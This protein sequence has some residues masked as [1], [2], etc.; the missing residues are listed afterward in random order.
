[1]KNPPGGRIA[2]MGACYAL[3]TFA[4]NFYKQAAVLLAAAAALTDMESLATVLFSLP[5]VL[6]S[7]WAG[8]LADRVPK[9]RLIIAAKTLELAAMLA[10][11]CFLATV[12]WTG[13][14]AVMFLMAA[15]STLFSPAINGA[16]PEYFPPDKV[17]GVN[18]AIKAAS[19]LAI[20]AGM[21]L[22]GFF[23][24]LR[25]QFLEGAL[26]PPIS[27]EDPGAP[28]RAAAGLFLL[29]ISTA[30]I[31]TA[32]FLGRSPAP[33]REDRAPFPLAGPL[34]SLRHALACRKDAALFLAL[35]AD[36]WFYGV[37]VI[38]VISVANLALALGH[39]NT[40]AGLLSAV[41]MIGV[42]AGA[43]CAGRGKPESWRSSLVP[44]ASGMGAG[45]L[46]V[47]A[48]PLL[49]E[50]ARLAWL[51]LSLFGCGFC[52]GLYIIPLE[53]FIQIRP[54]AGE[55]GKIIAA[56]NFMAFAAMAVFG[57]AFHLIALLPPAANF[58]VY[59]L[60]TLVFAAAGV[61]PRLDRLPDNSLKDA[62]ACLPGLAARAL[63]SLRYKVTEKGLE[64]LPAPGAARDEKGP[65]ILFLPNHPALV[66]PIIVYSRL[67]GLWP[68]PLADEAR[69]RGCLPALAGRM[70]RAVLIPDMAAQG[71]GA[72]ARVREAVERISLALRE[73]DHVLLYPS[74]RASRDGAD[75]LGGNSAA[76]RL[77]AAAPG[78]RVVL[79]RTRGLWGSDFSYAGGKRPE[80]AGALTRG[81]GCLLANGLFFMP[82]R[83][84]VIEFAEP[85][86]LPRDGDKLRLNRYLEA[87]YEDARTP[88]IHTPRFFWQRRGADPGDV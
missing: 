81:F 29:G 47:A 44:A 19:T 31:V 57:A 83:R 24:D 54:A 37:S 69:M 3:G 1:M 82:R 9:K 74:G 64:S 61:K 53:S 38:A 39:G 58:L 78:A 5:F 46:L 51:F 65:G 73:G 71:K 84:V 42:A 68:R 86:D 22:A 12:N 25:P 17:P 52:G 45:L 43:L 15:Q 33:R 48:T 13:M 56:S 27:P 28:G 21:A 32:L 87:F 2:L 85:D 63:L 59:G 10:G 23:L 11:A 8:W 40:T 18:A 30:G 77:L 72:A 26:P 75:R 16:I 34:D 41:L 88:P 49:P 7:A 79:V 35:L 36:A 60:A 76:A 4:D 66:D 67:A 55:K 20:L 62:A 50:S 6:F 70:V 14:L 80:L